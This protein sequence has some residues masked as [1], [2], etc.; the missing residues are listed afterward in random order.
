MALPDGLITGKATRLPGDYKQQPTERRARLP[1]G[2][3][4]E[5]GFLRL[6]KQLHDNIPE[7]QRNYRFAETRKWML[8]FAWPDVKLAVEIEGHYRHRSKSG[9]AADHR[10]Y[11]AAEEA[12]WRV[13]RY[14]GTEWKERPLQILDEVET[15]YKKMALAVWDKSVGVEQEGS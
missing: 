10:K 5:E 6:W 2:S 9:F 13:L 14:P 11:R 8:D 1:A 3:G 4:L 7:P 12:G 15:T